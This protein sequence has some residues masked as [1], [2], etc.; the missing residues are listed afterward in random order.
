MK[1]L[2]LLLA[3]L[4]F[5]LNAELYKWVDKNGVVNYSDIKPENISSKRIIIDEQPIAK[6]KS[7]VIK[8]KPFLTS[9]KTKE[10]PLKPI[11]KKL[12]MY[13]ASWC[14]YCKKARGY[15]YDNN[16]KFKEYDIETNPTA[17]R[18]YKNLGGSG[19]PLIVMGNK[20]MQGFSEAQFKRFYSQ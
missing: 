10:N 19:V 1:L 7:K 14:G 9:I 2:V 4:A 16:I 11:N 18:K 13:S 6:P 12:V 20:K 3:L 15:F 17:K 5:P 8:F